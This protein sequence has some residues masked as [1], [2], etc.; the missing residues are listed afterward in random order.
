MRAILRIGALLRRRVGSIRR[1]ARRPLSGKLQDLADEQYLDSQTVWLEGVLRKRGFYPNSAFLLRNICLTSEYISYGNTDGGCV[2]DRIYFGDICG[3]VFYGME[4]EEFEAIFSMEPEYEVER[5]KAKELLGN[6]QDLQFSIC[7]SLRGYHRGRQFVFETASYEELD[8]WVSSIARIM[9]HYDREQFTPMTKLQSCRRY[10]RWLYLGDRTQ[11]V[12]ATM[13]SLN[14]VVNIMDSQLQDA[15]FSNFRNYL[16][17]VD[18]AFTGLFLLEL[19]TNMLSTLVNEFIKDAWNWFDTAVVLISVI[20]NFSPNVPGISVLRLLRTF[21]VFRLFKR[22]P[23]LRQILIALNLSIPPMMNAFALV[24]LV[25]C[26]YSIMAVSFFSSCWPE[27]FGDF[28]T[29]MFTMFQI[30]TGD[31]WAYICRHLFTLTGN[32]PGVAL[33]FVSYQLFVSF[34][35]VNV[36]I[37]VLLDEFARAATKSTSLQMER[38]KT[39]EK[40]P[41]HDRCPLT[42]IAKDLCTYHDVDDLEKRITFLFLRIVRA[43][44]MTG[45]ENT[46]LNHTNLYHGFLNLGC[47]PPI[48]FHRPHW[49]KYVESKKLC[50][51]H[52]YMGIQE[53]MVMI[54]QAL[55]RFQLREL[56]S[57]MQSDKLDGRWNKKRIN[58][59]LMTIKGILVEEAQMNR[60]LAPV[61]LENF[62]ASND[63]PLFDTGEPVKDDKSIAVTEQKSLAETL[64]ALVNDMDNLHGRLSGFEQEILGAEVCSARPKKLLMTPRAKAPDVQH[65][66]GWGKGS[67]SNASKESKISDVLS[68]AF[69]FDPLTTTVKANLPFSPFNFSVP[70]AR[71][72]LD[73]ALT[74]R[75]TRL[76]TARNLQEEGWG[77]ITHGPGLF[78]SKPTE[79]KRIGEVGA[80]ILGT[81]E[82]IGRGIF[83]FITRSNANGPVEISSRPVG[84]G[85][86]KKQGTL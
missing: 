23:S 1:K 14:F 26:I 16:N 35:L 71:K 19:L 39:K 59:A 43:A 77:F 56:S 9:R 55:R 52:G 24:C 36:V 20:A 53:F 48:M 8:V 57:V 74:T 65:A 82:N 21:R 64:E 12:I 7:T 83:P 78:G 29:T 81:F 51:S 49:E 5:Q 62:N 70:P 79:P 42:V 63:P 22:V 10:I 84:R 69:S 86:L 32:G 25:T 6:L 45:G 66:D 54:K 44:D 80:G 41:V 68:G 40:A 34:V 3:I 37:A 13:I 27:Y 17:F 33:F 76:P 46:R 30:L 50:D 58:T 15:T 11:I 61:L 67:E 2:L 18:S 75:S 31:N 60:D 28:F 47:I 73:G 85:L 4:E 72:S 38:H